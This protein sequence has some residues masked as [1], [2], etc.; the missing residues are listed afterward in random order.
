MSYMNVVTVPLR[1]FLNEALLQR[2]AARGQRTLVTYRGRP[3][4]EVRAPD[5][6]ATFVG[7]GRH[8]AAG[9]P[10]DGLVPVEEWQGLR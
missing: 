2:A 8:L 10:T 5:Q 6:P 9:P 1:R 7:R 3:Y 4:F